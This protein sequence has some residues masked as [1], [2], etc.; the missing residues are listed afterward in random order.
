MKYIK[1][2]ESIE[3]VSI[4]K[5]GE[6]VMCIESTIEDDLLNNFL[7]NNIGRVVFHD[8]EFKN[9][10]YKVTFDNIPNEVE[11]KYFIYVDYLNCSVRTFKG[12]EIL[13][14]SKNKEDI[15]P[16]LAATKYNL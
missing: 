4:I 6:Y 2:F 16:L 9:Y 5:V 10:P 15:L 12:T 1:K 14:H 7:E 13:A 3:D 11:N 8:T